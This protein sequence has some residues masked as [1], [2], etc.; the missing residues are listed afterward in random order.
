VKNDEELK[1]ILVN[2]R[3]A[4]NLDVIW[5]LILHYFPDFRTAK[6]AGT[7]VLVDPQRINKSQVG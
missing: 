3:A 7:A 6:T 2:F 4:K 1:S 5:Q